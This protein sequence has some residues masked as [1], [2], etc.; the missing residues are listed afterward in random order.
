M[1]DDAGIG[2]VLDAFSEATERAVRLGFEVIE[3]HIAHGYLAHSFHSPLSNRRTDAWGGDRERRMAFPLAV[4]RAIRDAAPPAVAIGARITGTD[5][6]EGGLGVEDAVALA[7]ALGEVGVAFVC[8]S[9][10]GV[11][12]ARIPVEPGYQVPLAARVRADAAIPT[13]AVGMIADPHQANAIVERGEAD[14]V[15]LARGFLDNP[16]W[17]WHAADALGAEVP[18]PPQYERAKPALWPGAKIARPA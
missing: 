4:A 9:S 17:A 13:R 8:V 1:L 15:A 18:R 16:R 11:A 7:S 3:A 12:R 5:W 2:R 14:L 6:I 10:G